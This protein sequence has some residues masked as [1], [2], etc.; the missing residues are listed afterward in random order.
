M[1]TLEQIFYDYLDAETTSGASVLVEAKKI[2]VVQ[3]DRQTVTPGFVEETSFVI[4]AVFDKKTEAAHASDEVIKA[5]EEFANTQAMVMSAN[6]DSEQAERKGLLGKW[7][8]SV[9]CTLRHRKV[10]DWADWV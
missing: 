5:I 10:D 7:N 6:I 2:S 8:Y 1:V 4:D 3:A 9:S